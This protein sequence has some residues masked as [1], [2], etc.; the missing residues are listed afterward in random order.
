M[1]QTIKDARWFKKSKRRKGAKLPAHMVAKL[2]AS[3]KQALTPA[4]PKTP[5][6]YADI[7]YMASPEVS[8]DLP[9]SVTFTWHGARLITYNSLLHAGQYVRL[10]PYKKACHALARQSM[11]LLPGLKGFQFDK[12]VK[13]FVHR[14]A[15]RLVDNDGLT[16]MFKFLIDGFRHEGL[17]ADDDPLYVV[18]TPSSQSKGDYLIRLTFVVAE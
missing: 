15:K 11:D 18:D 10:S 5:Q 14:E 17:I 12:P 8:G 2:S 7:L 3:D 16:A 13:I 6:D 9:H 1:T 4:S